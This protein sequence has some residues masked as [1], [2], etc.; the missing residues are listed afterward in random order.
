MAVFYIPPR[1][2][3]LR[4]FRPATHDVGC[5]VGDVDVAVMR[6]SAEHDLDRCFGVL[7]GWRCFPGFT[8]EPGRG[9]GEALGNEERRAKVRLVR[10]CEFDMM[11]ELVDHLTAQRGN[12]SWDPNDHGSSIRPVFTAGFELPRRAQHGRWDA[13]PPGRMGRQEVLPGLGGEGAEI[14][15]NGRVESKRRCRVG[16]RYQQDPGRNARGNDYEDGS[17]THPTRLPTIGGVDRCRLRG[18]HKKPPTIVFR[19]GG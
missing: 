7:L 4:L 5:L 15:G 12:R 1:T 9:A 17:T 2:Q 11:G 14:V 13:I 18:R 8:F 19:R 6:P 10:A 16:T 3:Q